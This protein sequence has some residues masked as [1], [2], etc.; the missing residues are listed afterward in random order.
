MQCELEN[1]ATCFS[2]GARIVSWEM[3]QT[4]E[5]SYKNIIEAKKILDLPDHATMAEIKSR[6][7]KLIKWW[8]PDKCPTDQNG[9]HEMTRKIILAYKTIRQYC[10]HYAYSF[11][12]QEVERYLSEEEWWMDRFGNDPLWGSRNKK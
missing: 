7:R 6:Y 2:E 5:M 4:K 10:E 9:C 3:T 12:K 11:E 1:S 8:H